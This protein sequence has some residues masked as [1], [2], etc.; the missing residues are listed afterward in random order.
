MLHSITQ[1]Y[2][3][4]WNCLNKIFS[5]NC[6]IFPDWPDGDSAADLHELR[7]AA[8]QESAQLRRV[9]RRGILLLGGL[10]RTQIQ[11]G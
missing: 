11:G 9:R 7:A 2:D 1:I 5:A 8:A 10:Q 4:N 3:D 6:V